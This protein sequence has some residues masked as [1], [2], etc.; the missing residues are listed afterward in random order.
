MKTITYQI[1]IDAPTQ[2]VWSNLADF[3][4]VYKWSPGV[5]FSRSTSVNNEGLGASRHCDL[6]PAG[7]VEERI[8]EWHG[9][10][11]LTLEIYKGKGAPPFKKAV[12]T[13]SIK[14]DGASTVV[15]AKFDYSMKYGPIGALMDLFVVDRFLKKGLQGLLAGLKHHTE[16][17]ETVNSA[18]GLRFVAVPA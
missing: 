12:A 4:G 10:E 16:T 3:G 1:K 17:G 11:S 13:I 2:K 15:T 8:I 18:K 6:I 7:S 9:G 14:A 5:K